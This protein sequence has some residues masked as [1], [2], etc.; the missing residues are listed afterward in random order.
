MSLPAV[1]DTELR[2]AF[3]PRLLHA[4]S[5]PRWARE[6]FF[7]AAAF[8]AGAPPPQPADEDDDG[9][10]GGCR[11]HKLDFSRDGD[12]DGEPASGGAAAARGGLYAGPH[13]GS[14]LADR[15]DE[16]DG[17]SS[18]GSL[19]TGQDATENRV[20]GGW[21]DLGRGASLSTGMAALRPPELD[22]DSDPPEPSMATLLRQAI[23]TDTVFNR[24]WS[25]TL[26]VVFIFAVLVLPIVYH[27][28]LLDLGKVSFSRGLFI[29]SFFVPCLLEESAFRVLPNPHAR[30]PVSALRRALWGIASLVLYVLWHPLNAWLLTPIM[31]PIF[32]DPHFLVVTTLLGLACTILFFRTGSVWPPVFLHWATVTVW[33]TL[34]GKAHLPGVATS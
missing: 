16:P 14:P 22:D 4:A 12:G 2:R 7:S 15:N 23:H 28:H 25:K 19:T 17:S 24:D 29:K 18:S 30:E 20:L 32:Y 26:P 5:P 31:R 11:P 1:T 6:D 34:G 21:L 10:G 13:H 33:L 8:A 3:A 27:S 9:A